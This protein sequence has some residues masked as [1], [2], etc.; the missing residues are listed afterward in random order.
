MKQSG[1]RVTSFA[2]V[3]LAVWGGY[4]FGRPWQ[5]LLL[6]SLSAIGLL[7]QGKKSRWGLSRGWLGALA[8]PFLL[9]FP[10]AYDHQWA[11][12]VA[13]VAAVGTLVFS[14]ALAFPEGEGGRRF[15][16]A[17]GASSGV[18]AL[19]QAT[20]AAPPTAESLAVLPE[21]SGPTAMAR[22]ATGRAFGTLP[23]PGHFAALQALVVPFLASW[24]REVR[25]WHRLLPG[26]LLVMSFMATLATR[27]LA[28]SALWV[29]A[30]LLCLARG[31]GG[32]PR[33]F[34][35]AAGMSLVA[36]PFL[37][38]R[39]DLLRYEPLA[40]RWVNW[41]VAWFGFLQNPWF[42]VGPGGIGLAGL[43]SPWAGQN[44]T[45]FAHNTPLQLL[46]EFGFVGLPFLALGL[47]WL[48]TL[49]RV[50]WWEDR[51]VALA[52]LVGLAHNLVDFSFYEPGFLS[53]FLLLTAW[54]ASRA[55]L[56]HR[57]HHSPLPVLLLAV[58]ALLVAALEVRCQSLALASRLAKDAHERI[59]GLLAAA[60]WAPWRLAEVIE[61]GALA[62]QEGNSQERDQVLTVLSR[63][64]W[65]A[66]R[67][68]SA[69]YTKA[70]LLLAQ[71][72]RAEAWAWA[73]EACVRAPRRIEFEE[74]ERRCRP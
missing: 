68:A 5:L 49:A 3:L 30:F 53:S 60:G 54:G 37:L 13:L 55:G 33:A 57:R 24:L 73:K 39:G 74:L 48:V 66:P 61:A 21:G 58:P 23:L 64:Q 32:A 8:L 22:L 47:F 27:S 6:G 36:L 15:F 45:P 42:G 20:F 10:S 14:W 35:W 11:I 1:T 63:R 44:I 31:A 52:V 28:G 25:G 51:P 62:L 70:L 46:A 56:V 38:H 12:H 71:G 43:L 41:Q 19:F 40:L 69:A 59:G 2:L 26:S 34:W 65:V 29:L 67:S 7:T 17:T 9:S 16:A 50:C 4:A 18:V 72:R